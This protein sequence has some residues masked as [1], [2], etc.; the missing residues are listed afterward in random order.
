MSNYIVKLQTERKAARQE[1]QEIEGEIVDL[2]CYLISPKFR[3]DP[4]VQVSDVLR[5]IQPLRNRV[6]FLGEELS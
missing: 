2:I 4:T 6:G 1:L 3:D 5:R